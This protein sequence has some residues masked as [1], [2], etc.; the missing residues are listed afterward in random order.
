MCM[1]DTVTVSARA[2]E[3]NL[4]SEFQRV[5]KRPEIFLLAIIPHL[6]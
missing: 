6:T 3:H 1:W 4:S 5:G 2:F